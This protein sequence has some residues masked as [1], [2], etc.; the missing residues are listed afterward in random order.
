MKVHQGPCWICDGN[1]FLSS[2]VKIYPESTW[3]EQTW[4]CQMILLTLNST[5]R[6]RKRKK[7]K[8]KRPWG[9]TCPISPDL[10]KQIGR[11]M[12]FPI[13]WWGIL[14]FEPTMIARH[15]WGSPKEAVLRRHQGSLESGPPLHGSGNPTWLA[16]EPMLFE[17]IWD[18][19][20]SLSH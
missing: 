11:N 18:D 7:R 20:P 14:S 13:L 8:K 9:K 17:S 15:Q 16:W 10:K 3:S 12:V 4:T 5:Y 19:F 1:F 6:R 2:A